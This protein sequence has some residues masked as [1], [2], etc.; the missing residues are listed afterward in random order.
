MLDE[1]LSTR[2]TYGCI[3]MFAGML[4]SQL[5]DRKKNKEDFSKSGD[6]RPLS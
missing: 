2:E 1:I 6:D 4:L 3:L 5:P